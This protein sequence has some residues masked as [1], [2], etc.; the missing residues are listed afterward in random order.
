M[1]SSTTGSKKINV[2]HNSLG[3]HSIVIVMGSIMMN[4][5]N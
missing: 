5:V 4:K 2:S 1:K 3:S